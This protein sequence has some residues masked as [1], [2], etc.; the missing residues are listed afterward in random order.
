MDSARLNTASSTL[1]LLPAYIAFETTRAI[2]CYA[3][4]RSDVRISSTAVTFASE[5]LKLVFALV[6]LHRYLGK[7]DGQVTLASFKSAV[8]FAGKGQSSWRPYAPFA[9]PAVL[10]SVNNLL[11]LTGLQM[12][13]PALFHVTMLAK[14]PLTGILHHLLIRRQSNQFAW[15]SLAFICAGLLIFNAPPE[16][17]D[18]WLAAEEPVVL[19]PTS[20]VT[21]VSSFIGPLIALVIAVFSACASIFTE[22]VMKKEVLFWVAQVWLY[23]YGTLFTGVSLLL[24]DGQVGPAPPQAIPPSALWAAAVYT[25]VII[26]TAATGLVVANILRKADNLVKLVGTSSCVVTIIAAQILLFPDL[27]NK[28]VQM[29]TT[30]GVGIVA[31]STWTY[32]HYKTIPRRS[33]TTTM[34]NGDH[35]A[36]VEGAEGG[37][38]A[39]IERQEEEWPTLVN[40]R[41]SLA[42]PNWKR[43]MSASAVVAVLT[44]LT[45]LYAAPSR[46]P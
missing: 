4:I 27:R 36:L 5:S 40:G 20:P 9:V 25:A 18:A 42:T 43:V 22:V 44:Y 31:I 26:A 29:H 17:L 21:A 28:T 12:T 39:R 2:L 41:P 15:L 10:Y 33:R 14:L 13:A 3:A 8:L 32:N 1:F 6:Y 11:Y 19:S 46:S 30:L 45:F 24:W 16:L 38:V 35:F 7:H 23:G 37:D 34:K